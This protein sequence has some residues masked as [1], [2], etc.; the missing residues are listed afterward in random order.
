[1]APRRSILDYEAPDAAEAVGGSSRASTLRTQCTH[2]HR[3]GRRRGKRCRQLT[4]FDYRLCDEHLRKVKHLR[5]APS[6]MGSRAGLGLFACG[7]SGDVVFRHGEEIDCFA[8]ELI[9]NVEYARRYAST[10]GFARYVVGMGPDWSHDESYARTA[11]SYANDGV[12]LEDPMMRRNFVFKTGTHTVWHDISWPHVINCNCDTS[13]RNNERACLIAVGDIHD[14]EELLWSYAG[15]NAPSKDEYGEW[16]TA[17]GGSGSE[18]SEPVDGYWRGYMEY[19]ELH[20]H[21]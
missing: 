2:R 13:P 21:D 5:V 6:K 19:A 4:N 8:G 1:M 15:T 12:N 7:S 3:R 10:N 20:P 16:V 9:D 14:G 17:A 11:L 18:S